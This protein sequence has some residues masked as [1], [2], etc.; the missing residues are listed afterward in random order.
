M[1]DHQKKKLVK[2]YLKE[3][4]TVTVTKA[5]RD[6]EVDRKTVRKYKVDIKLKR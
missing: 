5:A 3:N 1:A 2:D 4:P 6:L